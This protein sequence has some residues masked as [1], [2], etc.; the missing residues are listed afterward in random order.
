MV[1]VAVTWFPVETCEVL[2]VP[3]WS[4]AQLT[5]RRHRPIT[6][7]ISVQLMFAWSAPVFVP[8]VGPSSAAVSVAVTAAVAMCAVAVVLVELRRGSPRIPSV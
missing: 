1:T 5:I 2:N 3:G 7:A 8:L 6:G 4:P